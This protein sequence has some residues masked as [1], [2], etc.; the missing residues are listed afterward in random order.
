MLL[1]GA[2]LSC[3][4]S[5][6]EL[7]VVT[8]PTM[9]TVYTVK[10]LAPRRTVDEEELRQ[11]IE[12]I[13]ARLTQ[14]FSTYDPDS[15]LSRLNAAAA[16]EWLPIS[17]EML[18]V[19]RAALELNRLSGGAFDMTVGPLLALWGFGASLPKRD[20]V[21]SDAAIAA[22]LRLVGAE[23]IE[24][25]AEPPS[26]RKKQSKVTL[27]LN[28]LVPGYAA[29]QIAARLEKSGVQ[30]YLVDLGGEFKLKGHNE[31]GEPW[32]VAI[33]QPESGA[34]SAAATLKLTG[35]GLSTSGDYRNFF[36][37]DGQRYSHE[38][39]PRSGRPIRHYL[40]SVTVIAGSAM[41]ADGLATA[42]L[43]LG[44]EAGYALAERE[45][46]AALFVQRSGQTWTQRS[47]RAFRAYGDSK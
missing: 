20:R 35:V 16:D 26:V 18:T 40:A 13:L 45:K 47:T 3:S 8:G 6:G 33:E 30:H 36:E 7:Q 19:M 24:L 32:A 10:Y 25:R 41:Q 11:A 28:A 44:P 22:T 17:Q 1:L 23:Q 37:L 43:V 12:Q 38:I 31:R 42:L 27:D 2:L 5:G 15:E 14:Q 46:L 4:R 29:D 34:R 21:P 9:G 39:D